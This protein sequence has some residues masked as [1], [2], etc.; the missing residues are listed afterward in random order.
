MRIF[1]KILLGLAAL[2]LLLVLAGLLFVEFRYEALRAAPRIDHAS[3]TADRASVRVAVD[4]SRASELLIGA[5]EEQIGREIPKWLIDKVLP[6]EASVILLV[7][8]E[9]DRVDVHGLLNAQRLGP[10]ICDQF[11]ASDFFEITEAIAW[12]PEALHREQRGALTLAGTVPLSEDA[13]EAAEE[14][15]AE[16]SRLV[17]LALEGGHLIEAV[18]D[19]RDGG[20]YLAIASLL[21]AYGVAL[22]QSLQEIS[23]SSFQFVRSI[24]VTADNERLLKKNEFGT[25]DGLIIRMAVEII[26]EARN[27]LGVLNLKAALGK[28]FELQGE[29]FDRRHG[30]SFEGSNEWNATTIEYEYRLDDLP[31]AVTLA[32]QGKLF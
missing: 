30:L 26:P 8:K 1:R 29:D 6:Y 14:G 7:N 3:L 23:V 5:V 25:T 9:D 22:D 11:N 18:I 4:V 27:R 12:E 32:L 21:A 10:I 17:P 2:L 15:W 28:A 20:A 24:R 13:L 19:N 16:S 31:K